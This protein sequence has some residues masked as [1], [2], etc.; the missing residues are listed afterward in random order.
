MYAQAPQYRVIDNDGS[1]TLYPPKVCFE[2]RDGTVRVPNEYDAYRLVR[3]LGGPDAVLWPG[4]VR[5]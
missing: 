1:V 3:E 4:A 5:P 2:E